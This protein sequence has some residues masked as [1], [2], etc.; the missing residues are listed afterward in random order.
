[1]ENL[2]LLVTGVMFVAVG[3]IAVLCLFLVLRWEA[4]RPLFPS[5]PRPETSDEEEETNRKKRRRIRLWFWGRR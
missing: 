2:Q 5:R 3:V 4:F 1:M